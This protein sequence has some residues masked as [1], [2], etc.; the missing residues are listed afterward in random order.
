MK[1][2]IISQDCL[3]AMR[4][5]PDNSVDAVVTDPPYGLSFM[6]SGSTGRGAVLE[7]F[8]FIG[9]ERDADYVKLAV[10]RIAEVSA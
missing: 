10:T 8:G 9:I 7:G 6:G 4:R 5:M 1:P 3:A 2:R